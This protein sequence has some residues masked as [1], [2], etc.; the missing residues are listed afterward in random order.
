[1]RNRFPGYCYKCGCRVPTGYGF[2]EKLRRPENGR[3]WRVQCVRCC[4]GRDV[5]PCHREVARAERLRDGN[6]EGGAL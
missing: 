6:T 5:R 4:D 2:F 1:M 3:K